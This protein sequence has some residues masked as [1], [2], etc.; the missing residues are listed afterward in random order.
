VRDHDGQA[1]AFVYFEDE[2]GNRQINFINCASDLYNLGRAVRRFRRSSYFP[3]AP[4]ILYKPVTPVQH[5]MIDI[6]HCRGLLYPP[7]QKEHARDRVPL[8]A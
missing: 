6:L 7:F 5:R 1:L 3:R 8:L 4:G 2:P